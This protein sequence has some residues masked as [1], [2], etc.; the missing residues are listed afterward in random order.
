MDDE[1]R[2]AIQDLIDEVDGLAGSQRNISMKMFKDYQTIQ[3][4]RKLLETK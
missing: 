2:Q 3:K 1:T 4:L